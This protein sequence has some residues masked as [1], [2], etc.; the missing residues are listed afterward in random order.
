MRPMRPKLGSSSGL[1]YS[2][3]EFGDTSL[4]QAGL[5]DFLERAKNPKDSPMMEKIVNGGLIEAAAFP[6]IVQCP[7]LV[8]E[9]INRYDLEH[10]CIRYTEGGVLLNINRE[11]IMAI[12][13]ILLKE[14]YEDWTIDSSYGFFHEKKATYRFK[15]A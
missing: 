13:K 4:E 9:C 3:P 6:T 15:V 1:V 14:P 10:M 8:L 5:E 2:L 11:T 7:E 12:M